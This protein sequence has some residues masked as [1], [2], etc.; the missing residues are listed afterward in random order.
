[1]IEYLILS[2]LLTLVP[3]V[4][5]TDT[6]T[7]SLPLPIAFNTVYQK[8]TLDLGALLEWKR[9]QD[10]PSAGKSDCAWGRMAETGHGFNRAWSIK[11]WDAGLPKLAVNFQYHFRRQAGSL[12]GLMVL[13]D[14][15]FT[16]IASFHNQ[17]HQV[18]KNC[19]ISTS[20]PWRASP[21]LF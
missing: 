4:I 3:D 7:H 5:N 8:R 17:C 18:F 15:W 14:G 11:R 16:Q 1:M 21:F 10:H 20:L 12:G 6:H 19:N 9:E 2:C 13:A